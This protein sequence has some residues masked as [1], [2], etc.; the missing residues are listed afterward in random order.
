MKLDPK[1]SSLQP[2]HMNEDSLFKECSGFYKY[3]EA[4]FIGL[5]PLR[6]PTYLSNYPLLPSRHHAGSGRLQLSMLTMDS[7]TSCL[8]SPV[9]PIIKQ[10]RRMLRFS[11]EDLMEQV[12]I[13]FPY[14]DEN[15]LGEADALVKIEDGKLV[16][17]S[18]PEGQ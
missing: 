9:V 8:E 4:I 10:L 1:P 13:I 12:K 5:L 18:L 16:P 11:T 17:Y 3:G 15:R 14:I 7:P 2:L 6:W